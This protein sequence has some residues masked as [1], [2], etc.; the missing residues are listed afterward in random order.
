MDTTIYNYY[1]NKFREEQLPK[2]RSIMKTQYQICEEILLINEIAIQE[3][4]L[5]S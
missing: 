3:Q 2:S 4:I 5:Q 1:M